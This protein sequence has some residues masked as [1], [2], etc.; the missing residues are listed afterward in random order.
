MPAARWILLGMCVLFL[1]DRHHA[2]LPRAQ[3]K[4]DH[5]GEQGSLR[6][7][8]S[9]K[10]QENKVKAPGLFIP[11]RPGADT[12]IAGLAAPHRDSVCKKA[13]QS[14][15]SADAKAVQFVFCRDMCV[16]EN[17]LRGV[18]VELSAASGQQRRRTCE[19]SK[20]GKAAFSRV[21]APHRGCFF[22]CAQ[23]RGYFAPV[24]RT[25]RMSTTLCVTSVPGT[26]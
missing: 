21:S 12:V 24:G 1:R 15:A 7:H 6:R 8:V 9:R 5:R 2:L 18:S 16:A 23:R 13:S 10:T 17:T 3:A 25:L 19:S 14:F 22:I 20:S 26:V 11:N 4:P